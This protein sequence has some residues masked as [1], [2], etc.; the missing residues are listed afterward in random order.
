MKR[1]IILTGMALLI[2][3]GVLAQS[4]DQT[5]TQTQLQNGT[6]NQTQTQLQTE[7]RIRLRPSCRT[8][9]RIRLRPNCRMELRRKLRSRMENRLRPRL[10]Q[11]CKQVISLQQGRGISSGCMTRQEQVTRSREGIRPG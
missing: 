10:S 7:P 2:S 5:Q 6:Q 3:A 8:E 9:P 4:G 11:N 1:T